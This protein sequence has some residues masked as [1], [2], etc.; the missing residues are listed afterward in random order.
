[1]SCTLSHN[2]QQSLKETVELIDSLAEQNHKAIHWLNFPE[3]TRILANEWTRNA[4]LMI[5]NQRYLTDQL[6]LMGALT[7]YST[8]NSKGLSY[9]LNRDGT[10]QHWLSHFRL[11]DSWD[12]TIS[13]GKKTYLNNVNH[14]TV[15]V[16]IR[17]VW[18]TYWCRT[19]LT[20]ELL[21]FD[22]NIK[23]HRTRSSSVNPSFERDQFSTDHAVAL[24]P[25]ISARPE[26]HKKAAVNRRFHSQTV[27]ST[28]I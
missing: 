1:M 10:S 27:V 26:R 15:L 25:Y 20:A 23:L 19:S 6:V 24:L 7:S 16:C 17:L 28:T 3:T 8:M 14:Y 11:R 18:T 4:T 22:G 5:T 13:Q 12:L 2:A 9:S 21:K